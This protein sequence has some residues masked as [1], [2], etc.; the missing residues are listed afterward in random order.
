VFAEIQRLGDVSDAEMARVFN[1]GL[2]MVVVVPPDDA[3]RALG[4]LRDT[5][6][7]ATEVGR[8]VAAAGDGREV[9]LR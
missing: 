7:A 8:L 2:G 1:L 5:G 6:H 3:S 4:V 9:R